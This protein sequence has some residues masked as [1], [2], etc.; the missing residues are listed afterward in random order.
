MPLARRL[1][2]SSLSQGDRFEEF[3]TKNQP[4]SRRLSNNGDPTSVSSSSRRN[5]ISRDKGQRLLKRRA[6]SSNS[7][8]QNRNQSTVRPMSSSLKNTENT[9]S[10]P[11]PKKQRTARNNSRTNV[12]K[13]NVDSDYDGVES[14]MQSPTPYWKVSEL[15]VLQSHKITIQISMP[16]SCSSLT[17]T[18]YF[19]NSFDFIL[20]EGGQGARR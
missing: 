14:L 4:L 5:S 13:E 12:N 2:S 16:R 10:S 17:S 20:S 6:M 8:K 7:D 18:C 15:L 1:S 19:R 11:K 3:C 9:S